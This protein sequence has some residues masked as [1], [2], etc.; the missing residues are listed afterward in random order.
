LLS[1]R[2]PTITVTAPINHSTQETCSRGVGLQAPGETHG[3]IFRN[4]VSDD[5]TPCPARKL[6]VEIASVWITE[7]QTA[8]AEPSFGRHLSRVGAIRM[9]PPDGLDVFLDGGR[10][11]RESPFVRFFSIFSLFRPLPMVSVFLLT[12]R[13]G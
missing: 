9:P 7:R 12:M 2:Q 10:V 1:C 8:N 13:R 4:I 11:R 6:R 5:L 3:R